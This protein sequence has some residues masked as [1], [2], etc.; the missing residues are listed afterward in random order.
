MGNEKGEQE[1]GKAMRNTGL[2]L[3]GDNLHLEGLAI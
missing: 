1:E 3:A 2:Y